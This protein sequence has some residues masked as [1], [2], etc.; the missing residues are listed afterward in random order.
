MQLDNDFLIVTLQPKS[1]LIGLWQSALS[2]NLSGGG[3][4]FLV[5][6]FREV[7][8]LVLTAS[9][10]QGSVHPLPFIPPYTNKAFEKEEQERG[11]GGRAVFS[12]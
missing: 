7:V 9:G 3:L 12:L 2:L 4:V 11:G 8:P 5:L 6:F 1:H 10:Q